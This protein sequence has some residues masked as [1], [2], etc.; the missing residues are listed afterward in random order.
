MRHIERAETIEQ[1]NRAISEKN[2][3]TSKKFENK[4]ATTKTMKENETKE[5]NACISASVKRYSDQSTNEIEQFASVTYIIVG[6][7]FLLQK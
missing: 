7:N 3:K 5:E 2:S 4:D 1:A 6:N